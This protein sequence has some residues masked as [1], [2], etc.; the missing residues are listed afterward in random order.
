MER[1]SQI[2][3]IRIYPLAIPLRKPF[4]HAAHV[5][6]TADP[7]VVEIE[8]ADHTLG[9]GETL[10]REYV[11]GESVDSVLKDIHEVFADELVSLRPGSFAQALEAIDALPMQDESGRSV[12]AARAAVELA[13]LDAYSRH[14]GKSITEAVGWFGLP[15]LGTPGSSRRVRYSGVISG[16][17]PER[18]ARSVKLMRWY[19]LRDFKLK[20]GY[21]DDAEPV[22]RA[23]RALGRSLGRRT[24]LRLDA[25]GAW[26]LPE[27][28]ERLHEW[29]SMPIACV[30]EPFG[31]GH[32]EELCALKQAVDVVLMFD[33]SRVSIED[34]RRLQSLGGA[35]AFNIRISKNGGFFP[36]L[37]LA[38]FAR[39]NGI[40]MQLGCMVGETSILSAVGR[41]FIAN[42]PG[43]SFIEGSYGRFLLKGDVV[44]RPVQFG[45]GGKPKALTGYGWGVAVRRDW[46]GQFAPNGSKEIAL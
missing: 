30:E 25:N 7:L 27:A 3:H 39:K 11:T 20:V 21:P 5:R 8:L 36:A 6:T 32:D 43:L 17:E 2:T 46:L 45:Y 23:V 18:I 12:T 35:D 22:T 10:P 41:H 34:A 19:G 29:E 15:G 16:D 24:T 13:L 37:R 40:R 26:T 9:Y 31:P 4:R 42:V 1:R 33:E 14:F 44:K 28:V 38:D